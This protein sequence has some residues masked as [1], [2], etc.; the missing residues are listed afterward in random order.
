MNEK[1][2]LFVSWQGG[3][4]HA[5]RDLA[6]AKELHKQNPNTKISWLAHPLA[7]K[8]IEQAGEKIL[9]EYQL[10]ADYNEAAAQAIVGFKLNLIKFV[11]LSN[12]MFT[13]NAE[14]FKE[15]IPKYDFDL[16]IGDESFE[17]AVAL[18]N[19]NIKLD[20]Q[21][22]LIEDFI[23]MASTT[24]NPLE[25]LGVYRM[26]RRKAADI[27]RSQEI[28]L[29]HCFVGEP[30]DV[31]D[32]K[33]GMFLPNQR[34]FAKQ[35]YR[36]LGYIIRFDPKEYQDKEAI[37]AK[38]GY[39]N[40][41][42]II[43]AT[44]GT[45]AGMEMLEKCGRAY[46]LLKKEIPNLRMICV[47]GELYGRKPPELPTEVELQRVIHNLYEHYAACDIAV[48]VGGMTTTIELTALRCPFIYF[49]LENQFDQQFYVSA[50]LARLG[51]G[52]RMK[53]FQTSPETLA[54]T[55]KVNISKEA[56]W[57]TINTNGA[58]TTANLV[59]KYLNQT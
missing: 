29:T 32:T 3:L 35:Y 42:L 21:M 41:P 8:L 33:F 2:V 4:G 20:C 22:I 15:T 31:P 54:Q 11:Q 46:T 40:E 58:A 6:I 43:C 49:P 7:T 45:A 23:A 52:I 51:A 1:K 47:C 50:R 18:S 26:N 30:E 37:K 25:K 5:T 57:S 14:L 19:G 36:F 39:G 38:L 53:Y 48:V 27:P 34:E 10:S 59:N 17:I 56:S 16:V 44:G 24:N 9:P 12:K 13:Q 55:I 28:G